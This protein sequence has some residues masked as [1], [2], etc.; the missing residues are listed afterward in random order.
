[1][2]KFLDLEYWNT[3]SKEGNQFYVSLA[4]KYINERSKH[5]PIML[6]RSFMAENLM[7]INSEAELDAE[8]AAKETQ[9]VMIEFLS[10]LLQ[11]EGVERDKVVEVWNEIFWDGI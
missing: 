11:E 10:E 1:M 8:A 9:N 6:I 2:D 3:L 5:E 7:F 4:K